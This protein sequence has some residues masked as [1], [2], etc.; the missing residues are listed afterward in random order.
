[1][2]LFFKGPGDRCN[3][4]DSILFLNV[5]CLQDVE[6][7]EVKRNQSYYIM[8]IGIFMG[9]S[10][11]VTLYYAQNKLKIKAKLWDLDMITASDYTVTYEIDNDDYEFFKT[12]HQ[13]ESGESAPLAYM[14]VLKNRIEKQVSQAKYVLEETDDIK[15]A[16]IN[17]SFNNHKMIQL[18]CERGT[19]IANHNLE[20][21][22]EIEKKIHELEKEDFD[23][24]STP[25]LAFVTF[26]TQEG[27]ERAIKITSRLRS[28]FNPAVEPTNIIWEN[29]H[30]SLTHILTRLA[31]VVSIVFFLLLAVFFIFFYLKKGISVANGKYMNLNCD[32]FNR[33]IDSDSTKLKFA[34]IDYYDFYESKLDNRMTGALQC[35]CEQYNAEQGVF[36]TM[37]NVFKH[38]EVLVDGKEYEA[39]MCNEWATDLLF[40]PFWGSLVSIITVFLNFFLRGWVISMVHTIGFH[41]ETSQTMVIMIFV[42]LVQFLNT[43]ILINLVNANLSEAVGISIFS[44]HYPDFDF[45]WYSDVGASIIYTMTFNAM[46]P[47]IEMAMGVGMAIFFR[48]LD[49]GLT[50]DKYKT[51]SQ[52]IQ[53]Y[54]NLYSGPEYLVH[55]KYSRIL[56][57]V[58]TTFMYGLVL[59]WIFPVGLLTLLIDYVVEKVC[60]VYY[61]KDPPS[62]DNKL[63]DAAIYLMKWAPLLM[64]SVGFWMFSNRQI[65]ENHVELSVESNPVAEKTGHV[66]FRDIT[67]TPAYILFIITLVLFLGLVFRRLISYVL[68]KTHFL[69]KINNHIDENLPNYSDALEYDDSMYLMSM[70]RHMRQNYGVKT[71]MDQTLSRIVSANP[72]EKQITGIGVYDILANIRY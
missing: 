39:Q 64:F 53:Q 5:K 50:C 27:Y 29:S 68:K 3:N 1:L 14:S 26:E 62:Y 37:N 49:K 16:N 23:E 71:V 20:E 52:T 17:Y 24:I 63:N 72:T 46:W 19:A 12:Q 38:P 35:F 40:A 42:F 36:Q 41:T 70:E 31:V 55:F 47:F 43:T 9:L 56:N 65:F 28:V 4:D 69:I 58:F 18:L 22:K 51:S 10:L 48:I 32:S 34:L 60:I 66:L 44:G 54:I 59:P 30:Y 45:D 57:T 8:C 13:D 25:A 15:V 6:D 7:I 67:A 33:N 11:L 61:Y 2:D 21:K